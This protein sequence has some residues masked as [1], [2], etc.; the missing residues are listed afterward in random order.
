MTMKYSDYDKPSIF[1]DKWIRAKMNGKPSIIRVGCEIRY[2]GAD[3]DVIILNNKNERHC[4]LPKKYCFDFVE[5]LKAAPK[6]IAIPQSLTLLEE[7]V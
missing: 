6:V 4:V 1:V 5:E 7:F 3:T 2:G